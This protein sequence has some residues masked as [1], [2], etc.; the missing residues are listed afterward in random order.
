MENSK[1]SPRTHHG[2]TTYRPARIQPSQCSTTST[3]DFISKHP[4]R[5]RTR[6][7]SWMTP[8]PVVYVVKVLSCWIR[9]PKSVV[10]PWVVRGGR[11]SWQMRQATP[12]PS[13]NARK[14]ASCNASPARVRGACCVAGRIRN[15]LQC[16]PDS[17]TPGD[18]LACWTYGLLSLP[19]MGW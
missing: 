9:V 1:K 17:W 4:Y 2:L 3:T 8:K 5:A 11:A 7:G 14:G 10:S 12:A 6:I 15:W 19:A 18:R 13:F 16:K